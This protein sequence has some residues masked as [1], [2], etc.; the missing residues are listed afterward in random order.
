MV[1]R[2]LGLSVDVERVR[3]QDWRPLGSF[4]AITMRAVGGL[5]DVLSWSRPHLGESA[6]VLLWTTIDR[7]DGLRHLAG[8]RV[9]SSQLP[10]LECG[11]LVR[12]QRCF[13]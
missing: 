8:W 13:T 4:D 12:L 11:R 10:G 2:E 5:E 6:Q 3:F 9:V 1:V 7:V